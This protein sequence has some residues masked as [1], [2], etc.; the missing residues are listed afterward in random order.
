MPIALGE[1]ETNIKVVHGEEPRLE[2]RTS[3]SSLEEA[4]LLIDL[5]KNLA[6]STFGGMIVF[7]PNEEDEPPLQISLK[8]A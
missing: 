7:P 2:L 5:I 1:Q 3:I 4:A 6:E 8:K